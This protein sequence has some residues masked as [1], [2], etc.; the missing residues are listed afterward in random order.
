VAQGVSL[1]LVSKMLRTL[2]TCVKNLCSGKGARPKGVTTKGGGGGRLKLEAAEQ[3]GSVHVPKQLSR[4]WDQEGEGEVEKRKEDQ[5]ELAC[6]ENH[7]IE[8]PSSRWRRKIQTHRVQAH[9]HPEPQ[10]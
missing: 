8:Q 4:S 1:A 3:P 9:C 2:G 5:G 7:K 6:A 10:G